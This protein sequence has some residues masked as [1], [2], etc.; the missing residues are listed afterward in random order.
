[1]GKGLFLNIR[2]GEPWGCLCLYLSVEL[3]VPLPP[4]DLGGGK[5]CPVFSSEADDFTSFP[6]L[7]L[8]L[9]SLPLPHLLPGSEISIPLSPFI[10]LGIGVFTPLPLSKPRLL[11]PV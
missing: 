5:G 2:E 7:F 3:A 9:G 4:T 8:R 10:L 6:F 1:M 11:I